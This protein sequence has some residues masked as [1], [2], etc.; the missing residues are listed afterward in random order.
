[1]L[2]IL[3]KPGIEIIS[4]LSISK[5][6]LV[7]FALSLV[8]VCYSV[9]YAV[10]KSQITVSSTVNEITHLQLIKE[11]KPLLIDLHMA[12]G[13]TSRYLDGDKNLESQLTDTQNKVSR[14]LEIIQ[15]QDS[16]QL[17]SETLKGNIGKLSREWRE[18]KNAHLDFSAAEAYSRYSHLISAVL[19]TMASIMEES[20]LITDPEAHTALL[21][22][23]F[24]KQLPMTIELIG[25]TRNIGSGIIH[26]GEFTSDSFILLSNL[27][28]QLEL[29]QKQLLHSLN[30]RI[31]NIAQTE[32]LSIFL[33]SFQQSLEKFIQTTNLKI[34]KTKQIQ[35]SVEE[36]FSLGTAAIEQASKLH[37][38]NYQQLILA[39]QERK[40]KVHFEAWLYVL[41]TLG[42]VL[43]AFYLFA[44]V[45]HNMLDSILKIK[46]CVD[47]VAE[48]D[49]TAQVSIKAKDE[50]REIGTDINIMIENTKQLACKVLAV[51]NDLVETAEKNNAAA[52]LSHKKIN[53]QNQEVDQ[54]AN[55]M[56]QMSETVQEVALNAEQTAT[57]T[58]SADNDSKAG[59]KIVQNTIDSISALAQE[60]E[61]A[62]G[63]INELQSNVDG[64]GSVLDV[65]QGIA[66]QTNL[67][68]LNAAIE[69][70]RAGESG[71]G[72]AVVADEV[73]TLASKTQESTEE[74]R[75]MI[76]K[77]KASAALSVNA[78][79]SG[80]EKSQS[81]VEDA[82]KAGEALTQISDSVGKISQMSERI[83]SAA[84]EQS[85][86]TDDIKQNIMSVKQISE[87]TQK[88]AKEAAQNS[89]FLSDVA[90]NL[91]E[92]VVQ[93]KV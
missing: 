25:S 65:I 24:V 81:T 41:S 11:I 49:L 26:Q 19:A 93:F 59:Y 8:P 20:A 89:Q 16:Y 56:N 7:V 64:I 62:S 87:V 44:C 77:L 80:N 75:Q 63:S 85:S 82:K 90:G 58:S 71:R 46:H 42:L 50:I 33:G 34:L 78:M 45:S 47:R 48:G 10:A 28:K 22:Y 29:E 15:A 86:V 60:L 6:F 32:Q 2:N 18:I 91:K 70:A 1:M 67:L 76:D 54:V 69:A 9:Y 84:S 43:C 39:L 73:R 13:L 23:S 5:K 27:N 83:A 55:A 53:Q 72:F 38:N 40:S 17:L 35:I 36:Y 21:I 57:S 51:T 88:T 52:L 66:D 92:L 14:Q 31:S 3:L 74:I 79:I 4:R 12:S 37:E 30:N 61:A 68:A